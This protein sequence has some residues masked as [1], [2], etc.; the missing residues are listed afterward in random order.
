M[1]LLS[2]LWAAVQA[3]PR[4]LS[5]AGQTLDAVGALVVISSVVASRRQA[6]RAVGATPPEVTGLPLWVMDTPTE[7]N[8]TPPGVV[9]RLRQ[10]RFAHIGGGMLFFGFLLQIGG[11]WPR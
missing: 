5:V 1:D 10:S 4:W 7:P 8:L 11:T 9:D 3:E 6:G 2:N